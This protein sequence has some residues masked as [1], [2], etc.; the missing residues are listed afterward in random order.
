MLDVNGENHKY[1]L[2]SLLCIFKADV[3][4]P[5]YD[6]IEFSVSPSSFIVICL[7]N[8]DPDVLN[9]A[10]LKLLVLDGSK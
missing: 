10:L 4:A 3:Q 7:G 2:A 9:I 1:V 5:G 8:P 6:P